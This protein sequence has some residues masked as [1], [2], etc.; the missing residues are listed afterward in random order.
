M[1]IWEN[2]RIFFSDLYSG[3]GCSVLNVKRSVEIP[4]LATVGTELVRF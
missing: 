3:N 1:G 4:N 2:L